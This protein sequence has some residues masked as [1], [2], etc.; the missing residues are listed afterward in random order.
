MQSCVAKAFAKIINNRLCNHL[1]T[2]NLLC[3]EQ[4]GFRKGRSCQDHISS[5]YFLIENRKLSKHDTY[6]CFVDFKKAFDSVSRDMLW[7]KLLKAGINSNI[8]SSIK[9][10]YRNANSV[11]KI[12]NDLSSPIMINCGVKQGCLLSPTL[13]NVF[14]NDLIDLLNQEVNGIDLE[15]CQINAL[16]YAD[17]LVLIA[18]KPDTLDKLLLTLNQW[19]V[20]NRMCIN[21]DKTKIIHFRQPKKQKSRNTLIAAL[22]GDMGWLPITTI[23]KISCIGFWI[24]LNNMADG[25]LNK[26]VFNEADNLAS[27]KGYK[28]WIAHIHKILKS[29]SSDY[30]PAPTLS[31]KQRLQYYREYLTKCSKIR[32]TSTEA[33]YRR[34]KHNPCTEKYLITMNSLGGRRVMAG[35]RFGC[36]PLAVEVGR[37]TGTPYRERVCRLRNCGEVEDQHHFQIICHSLSSM[38]QNLFSHCLTLSSSFTHLSSFDKCKFLLSNSDNTTISLILQMYH[39]RQSL[40]CSN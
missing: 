15:T 26:Q 38:R 5:L 31:C 18:D 2:N 9:A 17:D 40:L 30:N 35:L 24:R 22:L 7:K 27:N 3:E 34:I 12:N 1:E 29:C 13:F 19:C 6:T 11:I 36:L 32:L 39:L 28:N 4:N 33:L 10:L 8:L 20:E 25:R 14:I 21:P 37:Y 23:T 16:V